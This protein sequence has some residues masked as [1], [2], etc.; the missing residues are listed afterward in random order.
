[1][2]EELTAEKRLDVISKLTKAASILSDL[3]KVRLEERVRRYD[4]KEKL[5]IRSYDTSTDYNDYI[6]IVGTNQI[7]GYE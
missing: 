6:Y 2:V 1:M 3:L 5:E 7:G 4:L